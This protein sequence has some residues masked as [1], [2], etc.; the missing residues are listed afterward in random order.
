MLQKSWAT[1]FP[2]S[3][4]LYLGTD[5]ERCCVSLGS[6]AVT[7]IHLLFSCKGAKMG[8]YLTHFNDSLHYVSPTV[9]KSLK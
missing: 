1:E 7:D 9:L 8:H 3:A 2:V 5:P 6:P 4:I